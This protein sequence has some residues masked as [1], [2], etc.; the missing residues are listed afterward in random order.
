MLGRED[1]A[2][3]FIGADAAILQRRF[4]SGAGSTPRFQVGDS[5]EARFRGG[6]AFY[7]GRIVAVRGDSAYDIAYDDGDTEPN[8]SA[9]MIQALEP[10]S[11]P[12]PIPDD[13][14]ATVK[15]KPV[16]D[17]W[18]VGQRVEA[19]FRGW[20]KFFAGE[21]AACRDDGTFEIRYADGDYE[22][23]VLPEMLRE[24]Q[25]Q[26]PSTECPS[27]EEGEECEDNGHAATTAPAPS[28]CLQHDNDPA[29][30]PSIALTDAVDG[31]IE[32]ENAIL[33]TPVL[34][35][36]AN[37]GLEDDELLRL[38]VN[39]EE[40]DD[41]GDDDDDDDSDILSVTQLTEEAT[42]VVAA[43]SATS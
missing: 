31:R 39:G 2:E 32:V 29:Q 28:S 9:A 12:P 5:V 37:A 14:Q 23:G 42:A 3:R 25:P 36:S 34:P 24:P 35:F 41:D 33:R 1:E 18:R 27:Q 43:L 20:H 11:L 10:P 13:T 17:L 30:A 15:P 4:S 38:S 7:R 8:V 40:E 26:P 22:V 16:S 21:I 6:N 19:R